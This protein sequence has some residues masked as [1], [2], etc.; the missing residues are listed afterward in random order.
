MDY[1]EKDAINAT[2]IKA[3]RTS[4]LHM[5]EQ[6]VQKDDT[7]TPAMIKGTLIHLA[8]LEPNR[9]CELAVWKGGDKRK[10]AGKWKEFKAEHDPRFIVSQAEVDML[11]NITKNVYAN[12]EASMLLKDVEE[13]EKELYWE[14][15]YGKAKAKADGTNPNFIL[16]CKSMDKIHPRD[17][18]RQSYN[19]G[20][21]LGYGWYQEG[22]EKNGMGKLPVYVMA[23]ES[24]APYDVW[25]GEV[26][27]ELV[28]EGRHDA[29]Q[30]AKKYNACR[31]ADYY[32]G[33]S[34]DGI[35]TITKP[36]WAKEK[37]KDVSNGKMEVSEL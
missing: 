23:I 32:P 35:I 1:F 26:D 31:L 3:G 28:A 2:S 14:G 13:T 8:I 36:E 21:H 16:E 29:I 19:M 5:H 33:V 7:P 20:Y 9:L 37:E 25:V 10:N 4:M 34:E 22:A 30:I 17:F 6:M 24:K 15:L 27:S 11:D 18:Q 12:K